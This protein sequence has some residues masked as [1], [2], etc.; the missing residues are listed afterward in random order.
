MTLTLLTG[1]KKCLEEVQEEKYALIIIFLMCLMELHDSL[2]HLPSYS[3][4][5]SW[6][7]VILSGSGCRKETAV[8]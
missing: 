3:N 7:A 6:A 2:F 1:I 5:L 4:I 8:A